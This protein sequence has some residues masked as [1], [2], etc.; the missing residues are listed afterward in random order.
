MAHGALIAAIEDLSARRADDQMLDRAGRIGLLAEL[1]NL[2]FPSRPC[3]D[4]TMVHARSIANRAAVFCLTL[5]NLAGGNRLD[6]PML[7]RFS[8]RN[9]RLAEV[10]HSLEKIYEA[11]DLPPHLRKMLEQ[12]DR[13]PPRKPSRSN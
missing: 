9:Q 13:M 8:P 10:R 5:R 3:H 6:P 12:L 11:D 7:S 2:R 1:F 4:R